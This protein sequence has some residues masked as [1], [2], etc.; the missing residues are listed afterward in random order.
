[1]EYV[2]DGAEDESKD[3]SKKMR[4]SISWMTTLRGRYMMM[5][6]ILRGIIAQARQSIA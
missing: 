1:V 6:S 5:I 2:H 3:E 4:E